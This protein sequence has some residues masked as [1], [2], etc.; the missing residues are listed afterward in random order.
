MRSPR[1]LLLALALLPCAAQANV[2]YKSVDANGVVMFSDMPPPAGA[3]IIEQREISRPAEPSA[4]N[5]AVHALP[6]AGSPEPVLREPMLNSDA[7]L[8]SANAKLDEAERALAEA[9][10]VRGPINGAVRLASAN[11]SSV[12]D[13]RIEEHKKNV[14][15]ARQRLME[16][17]RDRQQMLARH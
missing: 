1:F 11:A 5:G 7:I 10:R 3:R 14:R 4:T 15:M 6:Y 8:A 17:L 2:L 12:D 13:A 9:R 16:V